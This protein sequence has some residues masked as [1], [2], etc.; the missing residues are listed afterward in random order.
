MT[1]EAVAHSAGLTRQIR[2]TEHNSPPIYKYCTPSEW[3]KLNRGVEVNTPIT[4]GTFHFLALP[5]EL[6][7]QIYREL[8]LTNIPLQLAHD[9]PSWPDI[10]VP[11]KRLHPT[12]LRVCKT[13]WQEGVSVLY[14]ENTWYLHLDKT[15]P[16]YL[17]DMRRVNPT[18]CLPPALTT[19]MSRIK[20]IVMHSGSVDRTRTKDEIYRQLMNI[21]IRLDTLQL[22]AIQ[23]SDEYLLT[24]NKRV[25]V[26][27]LEEVNGKE[28]KEKYVWFPDGTMADEG[29]LVMKQEKRDDERVGRIPGLGVY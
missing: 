6:R 5:A 18:F 23:F 10:A 15:L 20:R 2:H 22:F 3:R 7:N 13:L 11:G 26:E 21:G 4:P 14:G 9:R 17:A 8:L 19:G 12:V 29:W 16:R 25:N 1:D 27:W 24:K 28:L